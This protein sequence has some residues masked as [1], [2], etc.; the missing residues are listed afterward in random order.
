VSEVSGGCSTAALHSLLLGSASSCCCW[1]TPKACCSYA[2][3]LGYVLLNVLIGSNVHGR[4]CACGATISLHGVYPDA[5]ALFLTALLLLQQ[6][7]ALY[8]CCLAWLTSGA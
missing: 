5:A 7:T 8:P 1:S 4:E 2:C 6:S 3:M